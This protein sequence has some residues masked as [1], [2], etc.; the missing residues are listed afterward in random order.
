MSNNSLLISPLNQIK[1]VTR[2]LLSGDK[3]YKWTKNSHLVL[4]ETVVKNL[5][6]K[7]VEI[8][9]VK[10]N[11]TNMRYILNLLIYTQPIQIFMFNPEKMEIEIKEDQ[12]VRD[13]MNFLS[14]IQI[15]D[16]LMNKWKI[17]NYHKEAKVQEL[18]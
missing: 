5:K 7:E 11:Q 3:A 13:I 9:I 14:K 16:I 2:R 1:K 8:K 12:E 15:G 18:E 4:I 10:K 6:E 17:S